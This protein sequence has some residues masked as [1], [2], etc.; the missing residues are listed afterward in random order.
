MICRQN[1]LLQN[2]NKM[3]AK[4]LSDQEKRKQISVRGIASLEGVTDIKKVT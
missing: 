2:S 1:V 3:A 4:P